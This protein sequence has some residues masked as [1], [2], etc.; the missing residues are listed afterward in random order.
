MLP[1][2]RQSISEDDIQ[3]VVDVLRG[4]WL[5]TGPAVAAFEARLGEVAGG[6]R[7]ITAT[8]GTAA[9]HMAYGAAGVT[10][11]DTVISTPMTFIATTA[12]ASVL[13]ANIVFADVE[14]DTALI[15]PDAVSY[16]HL[17]AHET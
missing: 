16:T 6:H 14:E 12:M 2:G 7:A 3:A 9:L 13:G 10:R 15:D 1:Y 17:R 5:T 8:S 4:D 11:G